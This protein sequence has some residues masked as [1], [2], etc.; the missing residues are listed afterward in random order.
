MS[1]PITV[2]HTP[3]GQKWLVDGW[4]RYDEAQTWLWFVGAK[5]QDGSPR[6]NIFLASELEFPS[7]P[8]PLPTH[9]GA[10]VLSSDTLVVWHLRY[11]E[12]WAAANLSTRGSAELLEFV[13]SDWV[14]LVPKTGDG[15]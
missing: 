15:A 1:D 8:R 14:E 13:G 4:K 6:R 11:G 12:G 3:S 2:T 5:N 7:T 10:M 9:V